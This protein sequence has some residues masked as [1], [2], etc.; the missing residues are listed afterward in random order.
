[1]ESFGQI[2]YAVLCKTRGD[3]MEETGADG[4]PAEKQ[5]SNHKGTGFVR[6]EDQE[7]A[8]ALLQLSQ[9]LEATLNEEYKKKS[10]NKKK[11]EKGKNG[12]DDLLGQSSLLKG[13][14]ELNG[15]RLV[16]MPSVARGK[17]SETVQANKDA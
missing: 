1:M 8:D 10:A 3:L 9:N 12:K 15:R 11:V 16:I 13:E 5:Q 17:V 6:F 14:L 4:K 2:K 7:D